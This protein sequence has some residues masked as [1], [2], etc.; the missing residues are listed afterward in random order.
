M[1]RKTFL[2]ISYEA[3]SS[4]EDDAEAEAEEVRKWQCVV[5]LR[6]R[7][8]FILRECRH[9]C[10]CRT[11]ARHFRK[12]RDEEDDSPSTRCPYCRTPIMTS[13]MEVMY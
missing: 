10:I 1:K 3:D 8:R 4:S 9:Y 12:R 11:C 7:R 2:M 5:C 13:P 6:K